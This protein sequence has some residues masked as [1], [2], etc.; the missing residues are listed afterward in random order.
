[1]ER[2]NRREFLT[3]AAAGMASLGLAACAGSSAG[4]SPSTAA[5]AA[6]PL[7]ASSSVAP[8]AGGP[9]SAAVAAVAPAA[10]SA[11]AA[12]STATLPAGKITIGYFPNVA[13]APALLAVGQ[14]SFTKALAGVSVDFKTFNAG[15][16]LIEALFAKAVDLGYVGP[17]PA[18]NGYVQSK[19]QAL[20]IIGGAMSGGASFIVRPASNIKAAKDLAG[21]KIASPQKGNTQDISL[22]FYIKNN[23]LKTADE[24]GTVS[25]VPTANADIVNLF[26][27]GQ[28]DG[29]WV[30]EP[31]ASTLVLQAGGQVFVDERTL[32][33]D[34][35]FVTTNI[36]AT[37]K[38]LKDRQD[39]IASFLKAHVA[40]VDY[41]ATNSADAKKIVAD[42]I[43]KI[44]DAAAGAGRGRPS[45]YPA[46]CGL[47][48]AGQ[49]V[50]DT[51]R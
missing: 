28:I 44:T 41:I 6:N 43:A 14:G 2:V 3:L 26:K 20:K 25:V 40:A 32:W 29:A 36:I 49:D 7:S 31:W 24:G 39:I 38:L 18:V 47:R 42:Q 9:A 1:M 19:G 33:P 13:H 12:A 15:P 8:S 27:L 17:S 30:P 48:S 21:K 37:G 23:G 16:A 46:G 5:S 11:S 34:G 50:P 45:V 51:G 4:S 10:S 22:R 35:K